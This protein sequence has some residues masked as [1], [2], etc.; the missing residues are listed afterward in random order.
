MKYTANTEAIRPNLLRQIKK[1]YPEFYTTSLEEASID[2]LKDA[3]KKIMQKEG[4]PYFEIFPNSTDHI[5][6]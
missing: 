4:V 2:D 1:L 5:Q 6:H 3:L